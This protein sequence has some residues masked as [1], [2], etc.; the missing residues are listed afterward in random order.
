MGRSTSAT[1]G[2]S[3]GVAEVVQPEG[4]KYA[5]RRRFWGCSQEGRR[6]SRVN[7]WLAERER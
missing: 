1:K 2:G 6:A 5:T 7:G 4:S 3:G